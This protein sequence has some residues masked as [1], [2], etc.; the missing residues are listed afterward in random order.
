[1]KTPA[2][3]WAIVLCLLPMMCFAQKTTVVDRTL[4]QIDLLLNWVPEPEFGGFY[5]AQHMGFF[6][7]NGLRVNIIS[8]GAGTPTVQMLGA[9][10][11]SFVVTSGSEVAIA[12]SVGNNVTAVYSAFETSPLGIMVHKSLGAKSLQDVFQKD[13]TLAL[14]KGQAY[15]S[16]L[17][18]KFSTSK[19][20]IV[21]FA[22]GIAQFLKDPQFGQQGFVFSEPILARREGV[23]ND[24]FLLSSEGYNPYSVVVAVQDEYLKKNEK[25]VKDFVLSVRQGWQAYAA[26][27]EST[28]EKISLL[29]SKM[30]RAT[31]QEA[32][33]DQKSLIS[34]TG[35]MTAERWDKHIDQLIEAKALMASKAPKGGDCFRTFDP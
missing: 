8:G 22:G 34:T 24:F 21:P 18:N 28:N 10:K 7:A 32:A 4:T 17:Q 13:I 26:D 35:T 27:P 3:F 29:N 5:A 31:L 33:R 9:G 11:A 25:V 16:F 15:V 23:A 14:Q 19:V 2:R 6:E 30:D 12:R 1:M 20:K